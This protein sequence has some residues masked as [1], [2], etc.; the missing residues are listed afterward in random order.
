MRAHWKTVWVR[1]LGLVACN[2]KP[3]RAVA[4]KKRRANSPL[5]Y[6]EAWMSSPGLGQR[7]LYVRAGLL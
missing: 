1:N 6:E 2:G 5:M 3:Q 4:Y 7:L